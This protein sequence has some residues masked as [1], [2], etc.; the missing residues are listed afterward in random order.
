MEEEVVN[1]EIGALA[2]SMGDKFGSHSRIKRDLRL[3]AYL[4]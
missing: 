3:E 2:H 4:T 1:G